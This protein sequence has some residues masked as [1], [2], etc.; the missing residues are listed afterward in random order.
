MILYVVPLRERKKIRVVEITLS[1]ITFDLDRIS[2]RNLV[3]IC[4]LGHEMYISRQIFFRI[5]T[6]D[7]LGWCSWFFMKIRDSADIAFFTCRTLYFWSGMSLHHQIWP[8]YV[9]S[10]IEFIYDI[11]KCVGRRIWRV[12]QIFSKK[13]ATRIFFLLL[14]WPSAF[15]SPTDMCS[16]LQISFRTSF[17]SH[18]VSLWSHKSCDNPPLIF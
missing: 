6:T 4:V 17:F 8:T 10:V 14:E 9:F 16:L 1:P 2:W 5:K 13:S 11:E 18:I 15:V 7:D 3:C 12:A